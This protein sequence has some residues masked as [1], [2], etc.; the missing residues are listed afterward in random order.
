[1]K[2]QWRLALSYLIIIVVSL[3]LAFITLLLIARPVQNR[4]ARVRLVAQN[5]DAASQINELIQQGESVDD[6]GQHLEILSQQEGQRFALLDPEGLVLAD[7]QG[8]LIGEQLSNP[9]SSGVNQNTQVF[10]TQLDN[11]LMY[12]VRPV[13]PT[14]QPVGYISTL[15]PRPTASLTVLRELGLGFLVAGI[16]VASIS[17]LL[18]LLIARSIA[19][20]LQQIAFATSSVA[21]GDYSH[22]LSEKGPPEIKQVASNFNVMVHRVESSQRA[23]RDFVSNVSHELKTPLTSIQGFS[24]AIM[25]GATGDEATQRRAA[26]IIHQEATRM[27]RLVEDLLDLARIDSGQIVMAK[28]QLDLTQI[29]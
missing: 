10:F 23:M 29:L 12:A 5:N 28:I 13:G 6:I 15:I 9:T 8:R 2:L 20:P 11:G 21:E 1:M 27:G 25:E 19:L 18:S 16:I 14:D 17:F 24:Q 22:Q 7:S 4:L 3:V 26:T